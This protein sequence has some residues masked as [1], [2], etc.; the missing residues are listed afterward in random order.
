MRHARDKRRLEQFLTLGPD[1]TNYLAGLQERRP[2]WRSH[3]DRINTLAEIHGRDALARVMADAKENT[4][5]SAE[6]IHNLLDARKRITP[7]PAPLHVTRR[8]DLLDIDIPKPNL[9]IY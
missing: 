3:V 8:A 4:A 1:A 2:N 5:F 7:E 6:Y 9:D